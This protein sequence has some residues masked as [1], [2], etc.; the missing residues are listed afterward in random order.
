MDD[1][2]EQ[3][4]WTTW[5]RNIKAGDTE[6]E[7]FDPFRPRA[8]LIPDVDLQS[9]CADVLGGDVLGALLKKEDASRILA[10]AQSMPTL[11]A[12]DSS[13]L[14]QACAAVQALAA[15]FQPSPVTAIQIK[16]WQD[17]KNMFMLQIKN[18]RTDFW[19][20]VQDAFFKSAPDEI[21]AQ[22]LLC[23]LVA[24]FNNDK[25][26]AWVLA[27]QRLPEWHRDLR[28]TCLVQLRDAMV[29]ALQ[30]ELELVLLDMKQ[31]AEGAAEKVGKLQ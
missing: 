7:I 17:S 29:S 25:T 12:D 13:S 31:S 22:P 20:R 16:A 11:Q 8:C 26:E 5:P 21:L 6:G 19:A 14:V 23:Q 1:R 27:E 18:T 3:L 28:A 2:L 15:C 9:F 30:R 10:V 24:D 4:F